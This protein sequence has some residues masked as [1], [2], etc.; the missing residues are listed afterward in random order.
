MVASP[1]V[2]PWDGLDANVRRALF[3]DQALISDS[4]LADEF[5]ARQFQQGLLIAAGFHSHALDTGIRAMLE[6]RTLDPV[7][8]EAIHKGTLYY[9]TAMAAFRV[10][11]YETGLFYFDATAAEDFRQGSDFSNEASRSPGQRFMVLDTVSLDQAA[12]DLVKEAAATIESAVDRYNSD[13]AATSLAPVSKIDMSDIR[14]RLLERAVTTEQTWRTTASAFITFFLEAPARASQLDS[15]PQNGTLE[16]HFLHLFRGGLLLES[17]LKANPKPTRRQYSTMGGMLHDP[18]FK[19]ELGL[20]RSP[21]TGGV[22]FETL[23]ASL[24]GNGYDIT[25]AIEF[26]ARARNVFGHRYDWAPRVGM[27]TFEGAEY[28]KMVERIGVSAIHVLNT[29]Y[30]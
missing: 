3:C 7:Q 28:G 8:Y 15:R 4:T 27:R 19:R 23:R 30:T 11:D 16:P 10:G 9:W 12:L 18:D 2:P 20:R 29:C 26:A 22:D 17:L 1:F 13:Y 6:C 21:A 25:D 24:A 14:T 5:F